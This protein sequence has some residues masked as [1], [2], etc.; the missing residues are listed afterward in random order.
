M[1]KNK[2]KPLDCR[3]KICI[4][5]LVT[6]MTHS[7]TSFSDQSSFC[8]NSSICKMRVIVV[9]CICLHQNYCEIQMKLLCRKL[10]IWHKD[11]CSTS[12]FPRDSQLRWCIQNMTP[13]ISKCWWKCCVKKSTHELHEV[14]TWLLDFVLLMVITLSLVRWGWFRFSGHFEAM[15]KMKHIQSCCT[16]QREIQFFDE[17]VSWLAL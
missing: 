11:H 12:S 16:C 5:I 17:K 2:Q 14:P 7:V 10:V 4:Q 13:C 15:K 9:V 6:S 1:K 8:L 3:Q